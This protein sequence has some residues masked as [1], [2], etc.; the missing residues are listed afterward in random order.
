MTT[1]FIAEANSRG[2]R[3]RASP[4]TS[5]KRARVI[6]TGILL[7]CTGTLPSLKRGQRATRPACS[8]AGALRSARGVGGH[9]RAP[10]VRDPRSE[11]RADPHISPHTAGDRGQPAAV[12]ELCTDLAVNLPRARVPALLAQ[13]IPIG[14]QPLVLRD[15]RTTR[16]VGGPLATPGGEEV[17]L[18]RFRWVAVLE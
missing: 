17:V 18:L 11:V 10:R 7:R 15:I 12:R 1:L 13:R 5:S 14:H 6:S 16:V 2:S 4:T 8:K 9:T 3:S